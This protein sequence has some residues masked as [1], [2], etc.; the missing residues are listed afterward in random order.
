MIRIGQGIALVD[1]SDRV[2]ATSILLPFLPEVDWVCMVL[3]E[4]SCRRRGLGTRLLRLATELSLKPVLGLDATDEGRP[5]YERL[6]FVALETITRYR[7]PGHD[8]VIPDRIQ[9]ET[10][11]AARFGELLTRFASGSGGMRRTLLQELIR[12]QKGNICVVRRESMLAVAPIRPGRTSTQI[13]PIYAED[14]D[15]AADIL[16]SIAESRSEPLIVDTPDRQSEFATELPKLGF[17]VSRRFIR[18]FRGAAPPPN[19][20]EFATA[21]PEFG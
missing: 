17:V 20:F 19:P 5:M 8:A 18:M 2:I 14:A 7:R 3:V 21:G 1:P 4:I 13:G 16:H 9:I 11:S 10:V 12:A 15:S 6:G